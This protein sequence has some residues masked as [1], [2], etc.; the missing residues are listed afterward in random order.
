MTVVQSPASLLI[1][2]LVCGMIK[3]ELAHREVVWVTGVTLL[4]WLVLINLR[5]SL[6]AFLATFAG[7][8]FSFVLV[9]KLAGDLTLS[10]AEPTIVY[11]FWTFAIIY[12]WSSLVTFLYT[13][14]KSLW[15]TVLAFAISWMAISSIF[16]FPQTNAFAPFGYLPYEFL[17]SALVTTGASMVASGITLWLFSRWPEWANMRIPT[18]PFVLAGIVIVGSGILALSN[19]SHSRTAPFSTSDLLQGR[20]LMSQ[21]YIWDRD[22]TPL[23]A[24]SQYMALRLA[25]GSSIP[26]WVEEQ[27]NQGKDVYIYELELPQTE[28]IERQGSTILHHRYLART[29]LILIYPD[30][31]NWPDELNG[32]MASFLD[33]VKPLVERAKLWWN[34]M[35]DVRFIVVPSQP[36]GPRR[37]PLFE[38][39]HVLSGDVLIPEKIVVG[40]TKRAKTEALW[41]AAWGIADVT[42]LGPSERAYLA[43]YLMQGVNLGETE[44]GLVYFRAVYEAEQKLAHVLGEGDEGVTVRIPIPTWNNFD[45]VFRASMVDPFQVLQHW[46]KGEEMGHE[47]YIR[48]LFKEGQGD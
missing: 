1:A 6:V 27:R 8:T 36:V 23:V 25:A 43:L 18:R 16:P 45:A 28:Y 19:L 35:Q 46:Q 24:G 9:V 44:K 15:A 31:K 34:P 33:A 21:P 22:G 14:V 47:N 42:E 40:W 39:I 48:T 5:A 12:M 4:K 20:A 13:L 26:V 11:L 29:I 32:A 30:G 7:T 38:G 3:N 10:G 2:F 37:D 41:G 17:L